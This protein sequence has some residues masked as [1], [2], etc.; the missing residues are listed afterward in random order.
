MTINSEEIRG[1]VNAQMAVIGK[2]RDGKF[3]NI[4]VSSGQIEVIDEFV[5]EALVDIISKSHGV[6]YGYSHYLNNHTISCK[7]DGVEP[8]VES[9]VINYCIWSLLVAY[10][11]NGIDVLIRAYSEKVDKSYSELVYF[12]LE[13]KIPSGDSKLSGTTGSCTNGTEDI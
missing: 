8:F 4:V 6:F 1:K 3:A 13:H 12:A 7:S 9:Y 2:N 5:R 10:D 11:I